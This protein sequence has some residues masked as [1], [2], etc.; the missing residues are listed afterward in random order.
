[1]Q[2]EY[3]QK[4]LAQFL[5]ESAKTNFLAEGIIV[6]ESSRPN[7]ICL[8]E[9]YNQKAFARIAMSQILLQLLKKHSVMTG[10]IKKLSRSSKK[11]F[12]GGI[13][14]ESSPP[15][16]DVANLVTIA[17]KT[18]S[19]NLVT[20]VKKTQCDDWKYQKALKVLKKIHIRLDDETGR[21]TVRA[22]SRV[23]SFLIP[24]SFH[25]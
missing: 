11:L 5:L 6:S 16:C 19:S 4:V 17:K 8:Q 24:K 23:A 7:R 13:Q 15:N 18:Q 22:G 1:L 20:T 14:S 2:E 10:N 25:I 12:A 21:M 9:E 3:N